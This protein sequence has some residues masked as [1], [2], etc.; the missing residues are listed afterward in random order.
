MQESDRMKGIFFFLISLS[1]AQILY[2]QTLSSF[3]FGTAQTKGSNAGSF[4][5]TYIGYDAFLQTNDYSYIGYGVDVVYLGAT[6]Q[7]YSTHYSYI[8]GT[9]IKYLY[10]LERFL[11][12]Q[13]YIKVAL[14]YGVTRYITTNYWGIQYATTLETKIYKNFALGYTYKTSATS[15]SL[16]DLSTSMLYLQIEL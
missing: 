2:A 16:G 9:Q 12:H 14:G 10:N 15:S 13:T 5:S 1:L 4:S 11:H 7:N 6:T 3:Q 8:L